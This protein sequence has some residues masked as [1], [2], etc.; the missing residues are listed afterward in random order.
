MRK[1]GSI[2]FLL[3]LV[4]NFWGYR[5]VLSFLEQEATTRLVHRLD[6]GDYSRDQLVEVKIP[7]S[8]PYYTDWGNYESYSGSVTWNGENYQYVKRKLSQDTLY[9]LCIPHT[10]KNTIQSAK[11]D[12]FR[13]VNDLQHDGGTQ[14]PG[15]QPIS[16]KLMLSEFIGTEPAFTLAH[17]TGELAANNL[18]YRDLSSQ[19]DPCT[20]AQ[21][22]EC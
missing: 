1:A 13:I 11:M 15:Q 7:L 14:K 9:L 4:F 20:P 16:I 5:V 10:E 2:L 8:L 17:R 3:I 12:Y 21:P 18:Y 6:A 22:P 19:F